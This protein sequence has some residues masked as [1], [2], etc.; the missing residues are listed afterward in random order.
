MD[1]VIEGRPIVD[2]TAEGPAL[3]A[4]DPLSFWGGYD[5]RT[6]E[7]SIVAE[8]MYGRGIPIVSVAP[9][10]LEGVNDG[11]RLAVGPGGR[12]RRLPAKVVEAGP[13]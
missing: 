1:E 13:R 8:E 2:G 10:A 4:R 11:D 9:A 6:G 3:V 7:A 12:I 5:S